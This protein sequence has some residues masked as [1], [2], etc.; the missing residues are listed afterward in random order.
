MSNS[1]EALRLCIDELESPKTAEEMRRFADNAAR[2]L[3]A[4]GREDVAS[5]IS[6]RV[7]PP[8][9]RG[10]RLSEAPDADIRAQGRW[11]AGLIEDVLKDLPHLHEEAA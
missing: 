4:M 7:L 3:K 2:T 10:A 9:S 8:V 1:I 6:V 5:Q 11:V